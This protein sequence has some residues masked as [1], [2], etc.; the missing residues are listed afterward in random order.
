MAEDREVLAA[1]G[2]EPVNLPLLDGRAASTFAWTGLLFRLLRGAARDAPHRHR[3]LQADLRLFAHRRGETLVQRIERLLHCYNTD[4]SHR[5]LHG[6]LPADCYRPS[7]RRY[8]LSI[9]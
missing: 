1:A 8:L 7:R 3:T 2:R 6:R 9:S 4:R 5:S